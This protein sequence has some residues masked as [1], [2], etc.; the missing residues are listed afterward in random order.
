MIRGDKLIVLI[1]YIIISTLIITSVFAI[2]E[3]PD[4]NVNT[5]TTDTDVSSGIP[6]SPIT[7]LPQS[8]SQTDIISQKAANWLE[9]NTA[10]QSGI[11]D[12]SLSVI[13]MVSAGKTDVSKYVKNIKD[14]QDSEAGCW[15]KTKCKVKDTSLATIAMYVTGQTEEMQKGIEWLKTAGS[16]NPAIGEWW[17][18]I[19]SI[20]GEGECSISFE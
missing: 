17:I 15:P 18:V 7:N 9:E 6:S 4:S 5:Q 2:E 10:E 12:Q 13:A 14:A 16:V 11:F 20:S 1:L 8:E 19:K 3:T